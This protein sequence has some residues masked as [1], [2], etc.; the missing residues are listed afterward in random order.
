MKTTRSVK[1][2]HQKLHL[3]YAVHGRRDL[4]WR[5]TADSYAIYISEV[6][7]QQTQVKTVLE[8][9]YSPFLEKFPTLQA[10]ADAPRDAVV[11]AW[12]GLGYYS[13]AANLHDAAMR[14][15]PSL[16]VEVE[17]LQALPGIGRNTAH[18]VA[19]FAH[20]APV[21]VMEANVKR[22][23]CRIFAIKSPKTD[24]L[25]EKAFQLLDDENPFDYNQAMMDIGATVCLKRAPKCG[26]CPANE[27]CE[28]KLNPEA[29]PEKVQKKAVP[30]RSSR[31]MALMDAAG[32]I[33]LT[34]REG[35]FLNGLY[36]FVQI[37]LETNHFFI[38]NRRINL[39]ET[40]VVSFVTQVYS[41]FRSEAEIRF[42]KLD[43]AGESAEWYT[44]AEIA[45]L[46]LSGVDHKIWLEIRRF[47][48]EL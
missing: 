9:F 18:A 28:G 43:W 36:G 12:E 27:I 30:T 33:H 6:M 31:A 26:E 24:D 3:W 40:A 46:A 20:H 1:K 5:N 16:P 44:P 17:D 14:A 39:A 23:V 11:K 45:E 32:K 4:P 22:V 21:P 7:L 29:Y 38:E 34:Q 35:K 47:L 37:P 8:R 13:R 48:A 42:I 15:A 10:L 25:W 41:H 19:A 2:F